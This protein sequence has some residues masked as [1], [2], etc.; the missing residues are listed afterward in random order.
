MYQKHS[1]VGLSVYKGDYGKKELRLSLGD[2][3]PSEMA[4]FV[5]LVTGLLGIETGRVS[6]QMPGSRLKMVGELKSRGLSTTDDLCLRSRNYFP[7]D[8]D[9][10]DDRLMRECAD[11]KTRALYNQPPLSIAS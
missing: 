11:Y 2:V 9:S 8:D 10:D 1:K 6:V 7:H 3:S 5:V 4:D